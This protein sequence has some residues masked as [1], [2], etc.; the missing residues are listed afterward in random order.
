L[1][2]KAEPRPTDSTDSTVPTSTHLTDQTRALYESL[3]P[4][5]DIHYTEPIHI[6]EDR[7]TRLLL[8]PYVKLSGEPYILDLGCGTGWLLDN[9]PCIFPSRYIGIDLSPS[10]IAAARAKHPDHVFLDTDIRDLAAV[11]DLP[12]P[13]VQ[14]D[15]IVST[16]GTLSHLPPETWVPILSAITPPGCRYFL[17]LFTPLGRTRPSAIAYT[18]PHLIH[19]P[20][21]RTLRRL[22]LDHRLPPAKIFGLNPWGDQIPDRLRGQATRDVADAMLV[23]SAQS[24]RPPD[25]CHLLGIVGRRSR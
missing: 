13:P 19:T 17:T 20:S 15:L 12:R 23:D 14:P 24:Q 3:A 1:K 18:H 21:S 22:L 9:F 2:N 25:R 16:F 7:A 10:M 11:L 8:T 6:A 5:Y 4:T